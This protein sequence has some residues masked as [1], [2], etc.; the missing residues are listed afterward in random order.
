MKNQNLS[1]EYLKSAIPLATVI[2]SIIELH[3]GKG[4]CPFHADRNPSLSIKGE[5]FRCFACGEHGDVIDFVKKYHHLDTSGAI[6]ML[7]TK[8][9][10]KPGTITPSERVAMQRERSKRE[11]RAALVA[12]Y[13]AWIHEH[14]LETA[15]S[16][17]ILRKVKADWTDFSLCGLEKLAAVQIEI[18]YM[19][20][21]YSEVFCGKNEAE[22]L[23]L[24]KRRKG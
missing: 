17:R 9:G 16:L 7:A 3:N 4:L 6:K 18:D 2:G 8:A 1:I 11:S 19:E 21:F 20:Y 14:E 10:I 12:R 24:Y 23:S 5:R 15:L 13:K 22:R